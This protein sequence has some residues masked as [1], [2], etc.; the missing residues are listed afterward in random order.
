M[1]ALIVHTFQRTDHIEK[2]FKK[3]KL[4]VKE[5][6]FDPWLAKVLV[7]ELLWGKKRLAG[8][9]KPVKTILAYEQI[10]KAHLSDVSYNDDKEVE[11]GN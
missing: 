2:L 5:P 4:L 9:S 6:R 11:Q 10:L 1:Y 8:E 3:S 7:T